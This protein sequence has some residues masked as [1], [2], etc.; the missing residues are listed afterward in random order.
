MGIMINNYRDPYETTS[1]MESNRD[2]C[3]GLVEMF[4]FGKKGGFYD[5]EE[6]PLRSST[7]LRFIHRLPPRP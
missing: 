1:I 6:T 7:S 4:C 5:C 3:R 2:L